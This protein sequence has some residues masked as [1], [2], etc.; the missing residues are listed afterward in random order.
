MT[1]APLSLRERK[2]RATRAALSE[3]ALRLAAEHGAE[4]VTVE[5]I[6][7][8]VG[9]SPRTFFNYFDSRDD[10]FTM[11]DAES[12]QR[13]RDAVMAAPPAVSALDAVTGALADELAQL[14]ARQDVWALHAEVLRRSPDLLA[15]TMGA[16]MADE[17]EL[18]A[19]I[20]RRVGARRDGAA[21]DGAARDGASPD[22]YPHLL[23]AAAGTAVRVSVEHW[24]RHA[25]EEP[26]PA[27]FRGACAHLAA[28]LPDPPTGA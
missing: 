15:R 24:S 13:V 7:D 9:V 14:G 10:A 5:A 2:K 20:A 19:A 18:A 11:I 16:H 26:L 23:A 22:L 12:A 17:L 8:A 6:S 25:G 28:G 1:D 27:V 3:A 4:H 21:R